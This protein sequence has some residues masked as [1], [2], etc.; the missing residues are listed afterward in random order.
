MYRKERAV[1][2]EVRGKGKVEE[3]REMEV[4]MEAEASPG[5]AG[6]TGVGAVAGGLG[7][8]LSHIALV[9]GTTRKAPLLA[10]FQRSTREEG[11]SSG[12]GLA[13]TFGSFADY[14]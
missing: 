13:S 6:K 5:G 7:K 11:L 4:V 14:W 10:A 1:K 9:R 8:Q 2:L 12:Y 3:R